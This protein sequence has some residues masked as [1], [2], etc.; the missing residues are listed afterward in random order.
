MESPSPPRTASTRPGVRTTRGSRLFENRI[1]SRDATAVA[2]LKQAG[3][4]LLGKTNLPEFALWSETSNEVFGQTVNPWNAERTA[5]GSSGGEAAAA[6]RRVVAARHRHRPG[7]L[8]P[9]ALPLLR[10]GGLQAHSGPHSHHRPVSGGDGPPSARGTAD[11]HRPGCRP[12]A[13][14]A[15]GTRRPGPLRPSGCGARAGALGCAAAAAEDRLLSRGSLRAGWPSP[16]RKRSPGRPPAWRSWDAG[17][18]PWP[19]RAGSAPSPSRW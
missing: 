7:R 16:F 5:G 9:A 14:L 4:I 10:R 17:C 15:A 8:Q 11:P 12:G 19:W 3:A 2:R 13:V 18:S 1:P 6:C